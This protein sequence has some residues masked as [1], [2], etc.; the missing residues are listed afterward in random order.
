MVGH[1]FKFR[2]RQVYL[3]SDEIFQV[4]EYY[5]V[6]RNAN[7]LRENYPQ[8]TEDK[9]MEMAWVWRDKELK[10][11]YSNEDALEELLEEYGLNEEE[12]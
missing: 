8:L 11:G 3:E 7:Y 9:V 10:D 4:H 1:W 6:E 5:V 2:N 12:E